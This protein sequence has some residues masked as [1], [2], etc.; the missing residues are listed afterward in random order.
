RNVNVD[1]AGSANLAVVQAAGQASLT[2][3]A[4]DLTLGT[5][6][7]GGPLTAAAP[8]GSITLAALDQASPATLS[9]GSDIAVNI[10][11]ASV[12][13]SAVAGRDLTIAGAG[14]LDLTGF[15]LSAGR[16]A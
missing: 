11:P 13:G 5:V 7:A 16:D 2:A 15:T 8:Q 6:T 10:Q 12:T 14:A 4:G 1:T 9:A 3:G